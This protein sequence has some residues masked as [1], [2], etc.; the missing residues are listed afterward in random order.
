MSMPENRLTGEELRTRLRKLRLSYV[1]AAVQLGLSLSGLH[2]QM[3]SEAPVSRQTEIILE[4]LEERQRASLFPRHPSTWIRR[5]VPPTEPAPLSDDRDL[6][7]VDM[8][9]VDLN[10]AM[11]DLVQFGKRH[12]GLSPSIDKFVRLLRLQL[13]Q[14]RAKAEVVR[15]EIDRQQQPR[16]KVVSP[17]G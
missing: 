2:H 1:Q 8:H 5:R 14:E 11:R 17:D 7:A 15:V 6:T 3:R 13:E 10:Y 4:M 16:L 9:A 12:R